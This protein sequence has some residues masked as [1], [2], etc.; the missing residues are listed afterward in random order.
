MLAISDPQMM[1]PN[2]IRIDDASDEEKRLI[3]NAVDEIGKKYGIAIKVANPTLNQ[4]SPQ[5]VP[6]AQAAQPSQQPVAAPISEQEKTKNGFWEK[7]LKRIGVTGKDKAQPVA[8]APGPA[9]PAQPVQTPAEAPLPSVLTNKDALPKSPGGIIEIIRTLEE[10]IAQNTSALGEVNRQLGEL[11]QETNPVDTPLKINEPEKAFIEFPALQVSITQEWN[12]SYIYRDEHAEKLEI[13]RGIVE[14]LNDV[15]ESELYHEKLRC[16][17]DSN[18]N[19][20]YRLDVGD[21]NV[22]YISSLSAHK[23]PILKNKPMITK[24]TFGKD[25]L[26]ELPEHKVVKTIAEFNPVKPFEG[27]SLHAQTATRIPFNLNP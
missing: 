8:P 6:Q 7:V 13:V 4:N 5:L 2:A 1:P 16:G 12:R 23:V 26:L 14:K 10:N 20:I 25:L 27:S 11:S 22:F 9:N 24:V 15:H 21:F 3:E 18:D 19:P 17:Y